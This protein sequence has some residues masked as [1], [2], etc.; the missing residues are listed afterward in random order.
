MHHTFPRSVPQLLNHH[1]YRSLLNTAH[2]K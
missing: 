2:G 1:V